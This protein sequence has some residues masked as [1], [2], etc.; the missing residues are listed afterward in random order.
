MQKIKMI[1]LDLDGTTLD[2]ESRL[3]DRTRRTLEEAIRR[4]LHV[5]VAS[6]RAY[7]ALPKEVLSIRG[8]PYAIT[9]NGA[10]TYDPAVG[11]RVF[12][13][14]MDGEK[15]E[16]L[17]ELLKEEPETAIEVFTQGQPYASADYLEDPVVY[18]AP[19]RVVPYLRRTRK[20]IP[21]ARTFAWEHRH[22]LDSLDIIASGPM[23]RAEWIGKLETLGGIYVT[24]S[25]SY[26][27]EI[28]NEKGGKGA[29][30]RE[31]AARLQIQ[32]DEIV[33]FGNAENDMDMI[34]FAGLGVAV[35]NS[36]EIVKKCAD[37]IAPSNQDEGVAQVLEELLKEQKS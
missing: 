32:P 30:L 2:D 25:V 37:R 16:Q 21:D 20:P 15:V 8:I 34:E 33:A 12:S 35:A 36:P 6:G 9:S 17:L 27:L 7:T 5:I 29:A 13:Y 11:E 22:E 23:E 14:C 19:A 10:A 4:G 26:R 3:T 31:V 24:S 1:A 18:G 28:S